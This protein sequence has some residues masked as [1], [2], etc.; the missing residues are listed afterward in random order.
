MYLERH[1]SDVTC[2]NTA[3]ATLGRVHFALVTI[4]TMPPLVHNLLL[5]I[6]YIKFFVCQCSQIVDGIYPLHSTS[7][8]RKKQFFKYNLGEFLKYITFSS[9][10]L[11]IFES[12]P[13]LYLRNCFFS[14]KC[15]NG[16]GKFHPR[17]GSTASNLHF[18]A[19]GVN[20]KLT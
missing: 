11:I 5:K 3:L 8:L 16:G 13:K 17:S 4:A 15:Q 1:G 10:S 6:F 18:G 9:C 20:I 14:V 2:V 12:F 19:F 7:L